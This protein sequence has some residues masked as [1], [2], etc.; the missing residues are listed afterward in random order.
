MTMPSPAR[1]LVVWCPEW[2]AQ[3]ERAFEQVVSLVEEL[4]PK[5]EVLWP[6]ACA[7]GARGPARYFGGEEALAGKIIVV[8]TGGGFACQAGLADGLFAA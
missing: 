2:P 6:G 5:V 1:V 7:I 4:C 8:V 3:P